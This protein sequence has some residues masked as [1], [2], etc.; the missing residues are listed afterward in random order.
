M[1]RRIMFWLGYMPI[2]DVESLVRD[3]VN[4]AY[5]VGRRHRNADNDKPGMTAHQRAPFRN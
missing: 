2:R 1:I 4:Q 3:V 5:L